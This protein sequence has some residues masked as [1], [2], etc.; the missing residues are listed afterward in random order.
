MQDLFPFNLGNVDII[1]G[2]NWL[3]TLGEV[4]SNWKMQAMVYD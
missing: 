2:V 4:R 1:L 3:L